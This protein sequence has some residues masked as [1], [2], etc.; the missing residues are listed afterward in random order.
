MIGK[1]WNNQYCYNRLIL[2]FDF[3]SVKI[4]KMKIIRWETDKR[5]LYESYNDYTTIEYQV[6]IEEKAR[7]IEIQTKMLQ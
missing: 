2:E 5:W 7:A 6:V 4:T 3:N 1:H